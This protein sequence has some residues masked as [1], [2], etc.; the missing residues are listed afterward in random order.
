MYEFLQNKTYEEA[1]YLL[2]YPTPA[3]ITFVDRVETLFSGIFEGIICMPHVL[4]RLCK[5]VDDFLYI[6]ERQGGEM[7]S[8]IE[9]Y[10]KVVHESTNFLCFEK[11]QCTN[12]SSKNRKT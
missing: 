2:V 7:F 12:Q 10:G 6:S 8:A 4:A 5:C 1:G 9:K 11:I 3:M